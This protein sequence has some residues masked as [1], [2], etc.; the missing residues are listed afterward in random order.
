VKSTFSENDFRFMRRALAL[1]RRAQGNVEPNPMVGALI[2]RG[3]EVVGEGYHHRYGQPH[4]EVMALRDAGRRARGGTLYVTLEPCCHRGKTPPCTDAVL[5]AGVARVVVAMVDPFAHVRGK[6]AALLRRAGVRV[7]VGLLEA[8]ARQLNAPFITRT[9]QGRSFVIAKWAQSL[10]GCIATASGESK[11]ISSEASRQRVQ[12][13]RGRMDAILVGI[14][15][16]LK[17]DPLLIARPDRGRDI[18]RIATRIVLDSQCRLPLDSQLVRTVSQ[19]P[20]MVVHAGTSGSATEKRRRK[21]E[22][23]GV[24]TVV[25]GQNRAGRLDIRALLKHLGKLEY[26]N[27]LVE[28]GGATLGSFFDAELVDEA[29]LFIAPL[30]IGGR[31]AP[32]AVGGRD[33]AKLAQA[34]RLELLTAE[35]CAGDLHLILRRHR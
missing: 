23:R 14:G 10:D 18:R 20:V 12:T 24:M 2:V 15:T 6:G 19:A 29:Q 28:G 17:D 34:Q 32:H 11:W 16:A 27:L 30:I 4:A 7:D 9:T 25:V 8:E 3:G 5:A 26:S 33:L 22:D 35:R 31:Q 1:A 21:L 13:L